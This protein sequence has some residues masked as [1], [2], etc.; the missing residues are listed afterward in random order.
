[1]STSTRTSLLVTPAQERA[2][3]ED[4]PSERL[5][6]S[7]G[8]ALVNR[9][10]Q[11]VPLGPEISRLV[12]QA[13]DV[14]QRHGHVQ[15]GSI[16]EELTSSTAAQLLGISRPTLLKKAAAGEIASFKV[17]THTRFR[18]EAVQEFQRA[19]EQQ[20]AQTLRDIHALQD[21]L[22]EPRP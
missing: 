17:G 5:R 11:T 21:Q 1:M 4:L 9:T 19:R 22:E 13:L 12:E 14:L 3:A 18:R 15:I 8:L 7:S 10:G 16:P 6:E 20:R 2:L